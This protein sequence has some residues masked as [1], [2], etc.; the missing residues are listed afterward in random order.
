[1]KVSDLMIRKLEEKDRLSVLTYLNKEPS[2]NIFIIGDIENFGFDTDFQTVYGEFNENGTYLSVLLF[3]RKNLVYYSDEI[4][5]NPNYVTIFKQHTF[6]Y[7][8][9]AERLAK[10]LHPYLDGF[11]YKE[12]YFAE[13]RGFKDKQNH[14]DLSIHTFR[15]KEDAEKL[16]HFLATIDEF[17]DSSTEKDEF[18][19]SKMDSI[20]TGNTLYVEEDGVVIATVATTAETS[21]S[22]MVVGVATAISHRKKGLASKLMTALMEEYFTKNKYLCLFFDNPKAGNIYQRLGFRNIDKWVMMVKENVL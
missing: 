5:F 11:A 14:N 3:Y 19:K 16:Y 13:A 12:M 7:A 18:V 20:G 4:Y 17:E 2:L 9:C 6:T 8:N 10:L 21:T 15:T 22:A 1:M